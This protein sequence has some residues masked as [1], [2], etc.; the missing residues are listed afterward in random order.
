MY[1][2]IYKDDCNKIEKII[3][4]RIDKIELDRTVLI[5]DEDMKSIIED[6]ILEYEN[7]QEEFEDYEKD[8]EDGVYDKINPYE[9]YGISE[10]D[11]H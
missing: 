9:E 3:S 1:I 4:S 2:E 7:L 6:M 10:S 11:F 5:K 8:V